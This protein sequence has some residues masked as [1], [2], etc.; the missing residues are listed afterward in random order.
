[1]LES[2]EALSVGAQEQLALMTRIGIAEVLAGGDRLPLI[3]DDSLVNS[4]PERIRFIHRAL[5]RA[6]KNLQMIVMSCHELLFD[7][8]SAEYQVPLGGARS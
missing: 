5:H 8:L 1:M 2:F 7:E 6:S 4:D 3:M